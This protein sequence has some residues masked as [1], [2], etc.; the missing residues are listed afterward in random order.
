MK[1]KRLFFPL[2]CVVLD[3]GAIVTH[4]RACGCVRVSQ[5]ASVSVNASVCVRA[6]VP[7]EI[8][9]IGQ[10]SRGMRMKWQNPRLQQGAT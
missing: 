9:K 1:S 3:N 7:F 5:F 2:L 8:Q 4:R 6:R 10:L